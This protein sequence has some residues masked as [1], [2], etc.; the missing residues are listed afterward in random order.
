MSAKD[1]VKDL[2]LVFGSDLAKDLDVS[3]RKALKDGG[4]KDLQTPKLKFDKKAYIDGN[5]VLLDIIS[6]GGA[7]DGT[8]KYWRNIESGRKKGA[9]KLPADVVGKKWQG[10][11]G[12]D[13]RKVLVQ[14]RLK[15]NPK[16][17]ISKKTLNYDKAARSLS[18]IIQRSIFNKGIKPKPFV[19]RVVNDGRIN[20]LKADL[21]SL[22]GTEYKLEI[23]LDG[24]NL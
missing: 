14:L 17:K 2:L 9:R 13:P 22:L 8:G 1:K 19:D 6:I 18:F 23:I 3:L 11:N 12:I 16:L 15:K 20:D 24:S 5:A 7:P 10:G 21:K 4:G